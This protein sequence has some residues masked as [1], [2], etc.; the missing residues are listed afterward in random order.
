MRFAKIVFALAGIWGFLV[1]TPMYFLESKFG[2]DNPP[3]PNHPELY[4]GFVGVALAFQ[5][6]FL[7]IATNPLKYRLFIIPS[8]IE[9]FSFAIAVLVL[10]LNSR[11]EG[12][13]VYAGALDGAL[14]LLF[15]ASSFATRN[16]KE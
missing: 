16:P 15:V 3:A 7:L 5:V 14:G 2:S 1:L 12:Q 9:K 13:M 11:L 4:Y 10:F 8:I 6:V